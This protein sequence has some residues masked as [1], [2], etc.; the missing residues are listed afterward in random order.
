MR[1][2][3]DRISAI[4]TAAKIR[5]RPIIMT[6]AAMVFGSLPLLLA[7]GAGANSRHSLGMVMVWGMLIGT[8]FTL[9]VLP[10]LYA[11]LPARRVK[12]QPAL[13]APS[14]CPCPPATGHGARPGD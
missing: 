13:A 1:E 9:F 6:T 14:P 10:A 3:L 7:S 11:L 5:L 4:E 12:A 2:R 8:L